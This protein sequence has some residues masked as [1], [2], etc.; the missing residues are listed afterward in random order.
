MH[1]QKG[2]KNLGYGESNPGL[3]RIQKIHEISL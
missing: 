2:Q 1:T 3:L